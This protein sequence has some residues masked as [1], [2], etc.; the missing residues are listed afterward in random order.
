MDFPY[1][2][3][4][5]VRKDP[6]MGDD[7]W[8]EIQESARENPFIRKWA[9]YV[10]S[11]AIA[12]LGNIHSVAVEAAK[13]MAIGRDLIWGVSTKAPKTRFYLAQRGKAWRIS[14]GPPTQSP[15]RFTYTDITVDC[16]YGYDALF[17]ESYIEDV[18]FQVLSRAVA[19]AAQLLEEQLTS[20]VVALYDAI[21]AADLAGGA[22][23]ETASSGTLAWADVVKAWQTLKRTGFTGKVLAVHPFEMEDLWNDEK[24]IHRFYFGQKVNVEKGLLGDTYLGFNVASTDLM[25]EDAGGSNGD[26][27]Y[28]IDTSKA[29]ALLM[30]RDVLTQPYDERLAHGVITS[31]RYGL[32][33]LRKNAVAKIDI[34]HT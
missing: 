15:E 10:T 31:M 13:S 28:L 4:E 17:S 18:P 32:G 22:V 1:K 5:S 14:E 19:D 24:F 12:A 6:E 29:A 34:V 3:M 11:D 21:A 7:K 16:E 8:T 26:C 23:I 9:E 25:T 27:A 2:L 20:D 30:R 33:T